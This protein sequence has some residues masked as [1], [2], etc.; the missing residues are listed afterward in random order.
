[1][2]NVSIGLSI[3]VIFSTLCTIVCCRLCGVNNGEDIESE[4]S[5][6]DLNFRVARDSAVGSPC[7][8]GG[9]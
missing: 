6:C 5:H 4:I 9:V 3:Y 8:E 7:M 1:M 2:N